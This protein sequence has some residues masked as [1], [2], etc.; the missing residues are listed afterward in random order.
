M[1]NKILIRYLIR[2]NLFYLALVFGAGISIYL[3][4]E[5][6]DRL[7][8]FLKAGVGAQ[9]IIVYFLAK[10]PLIISQIFPA[11]F[12]LAL[13]IQF[14]LM[15]RHREIVA[16]QACAISFVEIGRVVLL[17][18]LVWSCLL[19]GFSQILGTKGYGIANR[20]WKEEVRKKQLSAQTLRNIW[21]R[22]GRSTV[23]ISTFQ[24]F[25]GTGKGA[26]VY[27]LSENGREIETILQAKAVT[28]SAGVWR[29]SDV[30]II[31]PRIFSR[32]RKKILELHWETDP[33]T[34]VTLKS[35]HAPK[36]LSFWEL[37]DVIQGL[38]AAGSNVENL[39]TALYTKISYPCSL[40]VMACV[41]LVLTLALP[42]VYACVISG[43]L[44]IF[45]Y[46][47][48]FVIGSSAGDSGVLPPLIA[49]WLANLVF[50]TVFG[51][52]LMVAYL[53]KR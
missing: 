50:G 29:L 24:P 39:L 40:V 47:A 49:A 3:L 37:A 48:T 10:I 34:F 43:L 9:V 52:T 30:T 41:A 46:Y 26:V 17:Y 45:A 6:F 36:Y 22:D 20:I 27:M 28:V 21:F 11:V 15:H 4:I 16:L 7:D 18:A 19:F 35:D 13:I 8:N 5:L 42:N 2:Q 38:T 14:S 53:R 23:N 1:K 33:R 32:E 12:L 51:G 25:L 31:T 44:V